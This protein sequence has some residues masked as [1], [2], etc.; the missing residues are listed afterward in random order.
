MTEAVGAFTGHAFRTFELNRIEAR[1]FAGNTASGRVL[2]RNGYTL[3]GRFRDQIVKDGEL[4][5]GLL[6]AIMRSLKR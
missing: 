3:E 5:D 6:Y 4:L 2:G 1:V